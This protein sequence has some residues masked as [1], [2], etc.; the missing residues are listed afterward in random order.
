MKIKLTQV[1]FY[2]TSKQGLPLLDRN[3]RP[4]Q[5]VAIQTE[6]HGKQWLS[7]FAYQGSP[8]LSW[9]VGDEVE[10]EVEQKGQ[11][12]NFRLPIQK[13]NTQEIMKELSVMKH[14]LVQIHAMVSE[15]APVEESPPSPK[16]FPQTPEVEDMQPDDLG[17]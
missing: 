15:L 13:L 3:Q 4:F 16:D 8:M 12:L 2:A 10:I 6:T 7:G 11:Y 1:R 5:R 9:K 14:Y 17:F